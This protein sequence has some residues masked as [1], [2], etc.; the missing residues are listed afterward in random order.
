MKKLFLF[1]IFISLLFGKS[2]WTIILYF[3]CDNDL[4]NAGYQ[5]ILKLT[6]LGYNKKVR[7][8]I[9]IDN[10]FYD[11]S[12]FPKIYELNNGNIELKRK[13]PEVNIA[14]INFFS[15][16]LRYIKENYESENYFLI[17][18]SHGNGWYQSLNRAFLYDETDRSSLSVAGGGLR[19]FVKKAK[20]IL[21]RKIKILGFDV[22]L[23]GMVEICFEIFD[24]CD[25]LFASPSILPI[26]AWDYK[27]LI[28]KIEENPD[29]KIKELSEIWAENNLKNIKER[30]EEGVFSAI[31]LNILKKEYK[32]AFSFLKEKKPLLSLIRNKI[33]TYP[34]FEI[35]DSFASH[36]D[37]FHLLKE[38][39]FENKIFSSI[40]SIKKTEFYKK[41]EGLAIFFP[42]YYF[43]FKKYIKEYALLEFQREVKWLE[44][45]NEY[46]SLDDIRPEIVKKIKIERKRNNIFINFSK[47][48]DLSEI[49]YYLYL[50]N[51]FDTI[52]Y[53]SCEDFALW[54]NYGF[55]LSRKFAKKGNSFYSNEGLLLNNCLITKEKIN[56]EEGGLLVFDLLY[57]TEESYLNRIKR[58]IFYLEYSFDKVN[59]QKLDSFYGK[60]NYFEEIKILLPQGSYYLRFR[61]QTDSSITYLGVFIDEIKVIS[62]KNLK[63]FKIFNDT[64]YTFYHLKKGKYY[65]LIIPV[66]KYGN[67]GLGSEF[68]SFEVLDYAHI[69]S[70]SNP[71]SK[72]NTLIFD[73]PK[74]SSFL[75]KVYDLKGN[76]I[77]KKRIE[78]EKVF[79]KEM[80]NFKKGIYFL[81]INEKGYKVNGK[82]IKI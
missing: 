20:E 74:N 21:K 72:N 61:Y 3:A 30:K 50:F 22:C 34:F 44:F 80:A 23:M 36:I 58:D 28:K 37:F 59:F 10:A 52:F 77:Y 38:L 76:L 70:L 81:L 68:F 14:E 56:L 60:S 25:Y 65:L 11:T 64:N 57:S 75:L 82:I 4:S 27:S 78:K 19:E 5:E 48:F 47:S 2:K 7:T 12:P 9:L 43:G 54:E 63:E 62:F 13:L 33:Q 66:D 45:L 40:I 53:D 39:N 79:L 71:F 29:I 67:R 1:L 51:S 16:F 35:E 17:F 69:I 24:D 8:I 6:N 18:Y 42:Y 26:S 15:D 73:L 55:S 46:Y 49:N 32:K 31:D 41:G